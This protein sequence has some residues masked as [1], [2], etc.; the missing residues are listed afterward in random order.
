M[1][2]FKNIYF[3]FFLY[4]RN[5]AVCGIIF[6]YM[7]H[8]LPLFFSFNNTSMIYIYIITNAYSQNYCLW[9][10]GCKVIYINTLLCSSFWLI[11]ESDEHDLVGFDFDSS[12]QAGKPVHACICF[13]INENMLNVL[14]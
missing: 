9:M 8:M 7:L 13:V 1:Y 6:I 12:C 3:I 2:S 5:V 11:L 10:S 4:I 14:F